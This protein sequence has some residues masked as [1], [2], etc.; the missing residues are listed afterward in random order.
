MYRILIVD[1]E[2]I[3]R[4]G[5]RLLIN[6][7]N[8]DLSVGE[9]ENGETALEYIS[10]NR[11]DILFTDIKMPF[12]DG[13]ELARRAKLINPSLKIIIFSAYDEFEFAREAIT[14]DVFY[15]ILKPINVNE[16]LKTMSQVIEAC[17][18]EEKRKEKEVMLLNAYQKEKIRE[19]EMILL[20]ILRGNI[21][22]KK[23]DYGKFEDKT[24]DNISDID[25]DLKFKNI[26]L[27]LLDFRS[28]FFDSHK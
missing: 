13:L 24:K 3:E 19:K 17:K 12:M 5:I 18:E 4:N 22:Y 14:L 7:Y 20:D 26:R 1:D 16:F 11:V 15:Y 9:A 6:K 2:K 21:D 25:F 8:L 10:N 28:R 23:F 27:I